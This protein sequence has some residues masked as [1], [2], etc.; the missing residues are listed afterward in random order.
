MRTGPLP[1]QVA[2]FYVARSNMLASIAAACSS[3]PDCPLADKMRRECKFKDYQV[4]GSRPHTSGV[5][6][7]DFRRMWLLSLEVMFDALEAVE[8]DA[9][10]PV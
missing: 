7:A 2:A 8:L 6:W 4:Q 10:E 3:G 1:E 5:T 9:K